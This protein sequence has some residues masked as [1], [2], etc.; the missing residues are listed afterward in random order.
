MSPHEAGEK[1]LQGVHSLWRHHLLVGDAEPE[2]KD[3]DDIVVRSLIAL[4][5]PDCRSLHFG[6]VNLETF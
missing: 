2:V 3:A 5:V 1:V 4:G 6:V